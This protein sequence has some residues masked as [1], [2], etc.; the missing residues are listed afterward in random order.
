[1]ASSTIRRLSIRGRSVVAALLFASFPLAPVSAI[2]ITTLDVYTQSLMATGVQQGTDVAVV[3]ETGSPFSPELGTLTDI[4]LRFSGQ[5]TLT[6]DTGQNFTFVGG[7]A[8][9]QPFL[10]ATEL[11]IGIQGTFGLFGMSP[12]L[13]VIAQTQATGFDNQDTITETYSFQFSYNDVIDQF[14]GPLAVSS[15]GH[16]QFVPPATVT[17]QLDDFL[18][19]PIVPP[20]L[21]FF[22]EL[23]FLNQGI[24]VLNDPT[25]VQASSILQ[26]STDYT[27]TPH[28][29][30]S[31][32]VPEPATG[33]L[34]LLGLTLLVPLR[35]AASRRSRR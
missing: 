14:L 25:I 22:Y 13:R 16:A 17:G 19:S 34:L 3:P 18:A 10:V 4:D 20:E 1:M 12:P 35:G 31:V 15:T 24:R 28:P 33:A 8:I 7:P 26:V 11:S 5:V 27:F 23:S 29:P 30:P 6:V 32:D 2:T 21:V 9:P